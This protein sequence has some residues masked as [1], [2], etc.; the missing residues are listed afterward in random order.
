MTLSEQAIYTAM[1]SKLFKVPRTSACSRKNLLRRIRREL[2][3]EGKLI[4]GKNIHKSKFWWVK[5][6]GYEA[7]AYFF[8][9]LDPVLRK[10]VVKEFNAI[11][12]DIK[13]FPA[14]DKKVAD[15]FD[16]KKLLAKGKG[17]LSKK[18]IKM[19][20]KFTTNYD[21]K[22]YDA[23][24]NLPQ[25]A[26][27]LNKWKWQV[28][29]EDPTFFMRFV[30]KYDMNFDGRLSPREFILSSLDYNRQTVGSSLCT[31]CYFEQGKTL[32]ALF[33]YLD[34]DNNG[35]LSA[36]EIWHNIVNIKR[37]TN[38][39]NMFAF[40]TNQS[41]RTSAVNDFILKNSKTKEGYL[42]R[43]EFRVGML[44]GFWD[45]QADNIKVFEKDE[46][47]LKRLRWKEG[48]LLDNALYNYYRKKMIAT[49]G[50]LKF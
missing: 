37:D 17:N 32:D 24:A 20:K 42:T 25:I 49:N 15:P 10:D 35:L 13:A 23:S 21:A 44:L 29:T 34:C 3:D 43:N 14:T 40:G 30:Q 2:Y 12:K 7:A 1:W 38:K 6:W 18:Q 48:D 50:K 9:F 22:T 8:D 46:R 26:A 45:R 11:V 36:E 16:Y 27:A 33:L 5:Q 4:D 39:W 31:H 41:I 19:L 28:S 47:S